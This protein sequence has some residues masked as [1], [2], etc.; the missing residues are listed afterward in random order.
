MKTIKLSVTQLLVLGLTLSFVI[1]SCKREPVPHPK[2]CDYTATFE[3]MEGYE[4]FYGNYVI[5][6]DEGRILYP[7]VVEDHTFTKDNIF[8]GMPIAVSYEELVN[9]EIYC[10]I[11]YS[12]YILPRYPYNKAKITC[13]GDNRTE[14]AVKQGFCGTEW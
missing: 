12:P 1:S 5:K 9:E 10:K 7:C 2:K 4:G 3:K 6:L 14:E 8:E 11:P 13:I